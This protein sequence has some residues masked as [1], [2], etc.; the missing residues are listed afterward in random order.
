MLVLTKGQTAQIITVTLN[1]KRTLTSGYYLF[2]FTN[3]TT[4]RVVNKIYNFT[5]DDSNYQDRFNEFEINTQALFGSEDVGQWVY[6]VY[7]QASSS[8]TDPD[9][10]TMVEQGV[11]VLNPAVEFTRDQYNEATTFKQYQGT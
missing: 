5:E 10:L 1:E 8:N 9:G 7:E 2:V 11:M 4:Q 3:F 6:K